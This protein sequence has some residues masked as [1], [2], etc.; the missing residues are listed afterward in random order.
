MFLPLALPR[1]TGSHRHL[2][3]RIGRQAGKRPV[4]DSTVP[5]AEHD[6]IKLFWGR[7]T[8]TRMSPTVLL[9]LSALIDLIPCGG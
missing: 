4:I 8:G 7:P 3:S 9:F 2:W 1:G 5:S 6:A